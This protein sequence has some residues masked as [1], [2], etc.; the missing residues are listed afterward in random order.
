[1]TDIIEVQK[2]ALAVPW[3]VQYICVVPGTHDAQRLMYI[4]YPN[5]STPPLSHTLIS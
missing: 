3:W 2:A 1:M 4:V 5:A